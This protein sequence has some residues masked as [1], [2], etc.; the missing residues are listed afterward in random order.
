MKKK[1]LLSIIPLVLIIG[2]VITL[3]VIKPWKAKSAGSCTI[4]IELKDKTINEK[5]SY[6]K[7]DTLS[8]I[9]EGEKFQA[10]FSGTFMTSIGGYTPDTTSDPTKCEYW[11][12]Y[13]KDEPVTLVK[14]EVD[15]SDNLTDEQKDVINYIKEQQ[16][17]W[18][19]VVKDD[20]LAKY[21]KDT[22]DKLVKKG[23]ISFKEDFIY[24]SVGVKEAPLK[25]K[26]IYKFVIETYD[27]TLYA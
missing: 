25:N 9:L 2:V 21:S 6:Q 1:L 23:Y 18:V 12:F 8:G 16:A 24:S 3:V 27:S 15:A 26:R 19:T 4:I 13:Y 14:S 10:T 5:V 20:L 22:I 11:A 17:N 7:N